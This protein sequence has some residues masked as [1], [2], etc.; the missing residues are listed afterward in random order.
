[1]SKKIEAEPAAPEVGESS[2]EQ[3]VSPAAAGDGKGEGK[4]E[5][6][7]KNG[8]AKRK[9]SIPSGGRDPTPKS[10]AFTLA[11]RSERSLADMYRIQDGIPEEVIEWSVSSAPPRCRDRVVRAR[12]Q[13]ESHPFA[14]ARA[15]TPAPYRALT[16][17]TPSPSGS[18]ARL[19]PAHPSTSPSG[20]LPAPTS[21]PG[22]TLPSPLIPA[23]QVLRAFQRVDQQLQQGDNEGP[24]SR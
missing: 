11:A 7:A 15:A 13:H 2:P 21:P 19:A 9:G 18:P 22:F 14:P 6:P 23:A 10:F 1:M 5:A 3:P 17:R 4:G 8:V 16:L 24:A 12:A 20:L